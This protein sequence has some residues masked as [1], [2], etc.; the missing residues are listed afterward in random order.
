M[1][2][3]PSS[4]IWRSAG[5]TWTA[6]SNL[7]E[8]KIMQRIHH[9]KILASSSCWSEHTNSSMGPMESIGNGLA[10]RSAFAR[11]TTTDSWMDLSP[12]SS[13][14][15]RSIAKREATH[16]RK[17]LNAGI[18]EGP[19]SRWSKWMQYFSTRSIVNGYS[20]E[21]LQADHCSNFSNDRTC[22]A[23]VL[24]APERRTRFLSL[25]IS[26]DDSS[27]DW[28]WTVRSF[29]SLPALRPMASSLAAH[30]ERSAC[31][32][33]SNGVLDGSGWSTLSFLHSPIGLEPLSSTYRSGDLQP[34]GHCSDT[35]QIRAGWQ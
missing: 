16:L 23:I 25:V 6:S 7:R 9:T 1:P 19:H 33:S 2:N 28:S 3:I 5:F 17:I 30:F 21:K 35:V 31:S 4:F 32:L 18:T 20:S 10:S 14:S 29:D 13:R 27:S 8:A 24:G 12:L 34:E 22:T 26:R 15:G 11:L